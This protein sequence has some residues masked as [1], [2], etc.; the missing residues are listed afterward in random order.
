MYFIHIQNVI[1]KSFNKAQP[2]IK[3]KVL[4]PNSCLNWRSNINCDRALKELRAEDLESAKKTREMVERKKYFTNALKINLVY[5]SS[6]WY[7]TSLH[8]MYIKAGRQGQ[9]T[10]GN[11][12]RYFW[13][14]KVRGLGFVYKMCLL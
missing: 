1:N 9:V 3:E 10:L 14:S 5:Q 13:R 4:R 6:K 2:R 8:E 12:L 7:K 11:M